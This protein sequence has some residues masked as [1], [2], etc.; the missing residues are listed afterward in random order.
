M[1]R[2]GA[3]Y[4]LAGLMFA[5]FAVLNARDREAPRRWASAT[6]WG[7]LAVSFLVGDSLG[8]LA[9]GVLVVALGGAAAFTTVRPQPRA[10]AAVAEAEAHA[11]RYGDRL[12]ALALIVPGVAILGAVGLKHVVIGGLP[13]I[14]PKQAAVVSLSLGVV[15]ALTAAALVLRPAP[16]APLRDGRRLADLVGW[17]VVLPQALAALGAVFALAGVGD[18]VG[19]LVDRFAPLDTPLLAVAGYT[20]GMAV[21][22]AMLGNAFAAFPVMTAA[23][24]LPLVVHRFHGDPAIMGAIGMLSG[25]CGTL[26]TP[27]AANFNLVPVALLELPDRWAVIRVQAPTAAVLLGVN[28]LLMWAAVYRF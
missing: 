23:V 19:R 4:A 27:L 21:L 6:L 5:A 7:L 22:T 1:I 9:N 14:E 16:L 17:A 26:V 10:P 12:V 3:A 8:D 28:T 18:A 24:G 20:V 13:L 15:T 2:L 25:F 11:A